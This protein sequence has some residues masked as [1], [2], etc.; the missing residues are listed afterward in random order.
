MIASMIAHS[1]HGGAAFHVH[2]T[3]EWLAALGVFIPI[4]TGVVAKLESSSGVRAVI[5]VALAAVLGVVT[6]IVAEGVTDLDL[7]AILISIGIAFATNLA[8]YLGIWK[9]MGETDYVPLQLRTAEFGV[10]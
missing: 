5:A 2:A 10:S 9:P 6:Q 3:A 4:L 7:G 8:A 1:G